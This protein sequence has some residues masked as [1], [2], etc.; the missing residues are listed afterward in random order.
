[1]SEGTTTIFSSNDGLTANM[2]SALSANERAYEMLI[3]IVDVLKTEVEHEGIGASMTPSDLLN[4]IVGLAHEY[5]LP[6]VREKALDC[7]EGGRRG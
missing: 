7:Q 4:K 2:Q 1:M 3:K 6:K 5:D